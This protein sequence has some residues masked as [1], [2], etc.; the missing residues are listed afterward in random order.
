[1]Y[2]AMLAALLV[3]GQDA[4][5]FGWLRHHHH[6]HGCHSCHGCH[7]VRVYYSSCHGCYGCSCYGCSCH[8]CWGCYGCSCSCSCHGYYS[9]SSC[10][11]YGCSCYGCS[12]YGCYCSGC[13]GCCGGT[14]VVPTTTYVQPASPPAAKSAAESS[15]TPEEAAAVQKLLQDMRSGKKEAARPV[16]PATQSAK[17]TV[18]LPS[19]ARLW[20]DGVYCPLT[21]ATRSFDTPALEVGKHY[22]YNLRMEMQREGRTISQTQQVRLAAGRNVVVEFGT[23]PA[24]ASR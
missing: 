22:V 7:G 12:C 13:Y 19:D 23:S 15:L 17:V 21:S 4:S 10:S 18:K 3:S 24:T 16:V 2:S 11:C 14:V 1:M 9:Y 8:G 20:V 5:S 6:C